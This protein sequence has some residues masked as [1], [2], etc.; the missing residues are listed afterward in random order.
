[1]HLK[2]C[3]CMP[4]AAPSPRCAR[5]APCAPPLPR[6]ARG[7]AP[8][9]L[10]RTR[11]S[12]PRSRPRRGAVPFA[13]RQRTTATRRARTPARAAPRRSGCSGT[14][15][16]LQAPAFTRWWCFKQ[17]CGQ[18]RGCQTRSNHKPQAADRTALGC[19]AGGARAGRPTAFAL[20][21]SK[22]ALP[23]PAPLRTLHTPLSRALHAARQTPPLQPPP[24]LQHCRQHRSRRCCTLRG[25]QRAAPRSRPGGRN[26][27]AQLHPMK[28]IRAEGRPWCAPHL[29][30]KG[31]AAQ[32]MCDLVAAA[33]SI[34]ALLSLLPCCELCTAPTCAACSTPSCR[35][36]SSR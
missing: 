15:G 4:P 33:S 18:V 35:T 9:P 21:S 14:A 1:M 23:R 13:P 31:H 3:V 10:R 29:A 24:L 32:G 8:R 22:G 34:P 20:A 17:E 7:R 25:A 12:P 2:S 28:A 16:A 26:A 5:Q 27:D 19:L 6:P 36:R 11:R 30:G